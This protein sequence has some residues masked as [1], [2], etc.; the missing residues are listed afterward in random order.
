[1]AR[2]TTTHSDASDPMMAVNVG[3]AVGGPQCGF[4]ARYR[5][6]SGDAIN[7]LTVAGL[8]FTPLVAPHIATKHAGAGPA[9]SADNKV[10]PA[11]EGL[12]PGTG[13]DVTGLLIAS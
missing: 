6:K 4:P 11:N 13:E 1:M 2:P 10:T 3:G 8:M 9:K 12:A 5:Q 7:W